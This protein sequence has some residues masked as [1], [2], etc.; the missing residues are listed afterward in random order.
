MSAAIPAAFTRARTK[1][2][3]IAAEP[4]LDDRQAERNAWVDSIAEWGHEASDLHAWD[5]QRRFRDPLNRPGLRTKR[6]CFAWATGA[7]VLALAAAALFFTKPAHAEGNDAQ[8]WVNAGG[9]S[10]HSKPGRNGSNPGIGAELRTSEDWSFG[11]GAYRNSDRGHSRYVLAEYT[12][13]HIGMLN[14]GLVAGAVDGYTVNNGKPM[15]LIA[16]AIELRASHFAAQLTY[17]PAIDSI[18][19]ADT[20]SLVLK[21]RF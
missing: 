9:V 2:A 10:W 1:P 13:L 3:A 12:P 19:N 17:V 16:P 4:L 15:A 18:K 7:I 14:A 5:D 20:L 6:A 8:L 21:V 11:A